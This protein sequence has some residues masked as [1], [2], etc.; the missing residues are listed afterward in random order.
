MNPSEFT[1][2]DRSTISGFSLQ[3]IVPT[4]KY[5][6]AEL[7]NLG[8]NRWTF[9]PQWGLAKNFDKWTIEGY[10]SIW[11]FTNNSNYLDGNE[12]K[13]KPLYT[14]KL[15][16]IRDLPKN[17]WVAANIGYGIGGR[18]VVNGTPKDTHISGMRFGLHYVIPFNLNHSIKFGYAS[19]VRFKKGSDFDA[20]TLTYQY[21]WNKSVKEYNKLKATK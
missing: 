19:G 15:H 1:Q 6:P 7:L 4:G 10:A 2:Y 21:R 12:L 11:L 18:A 14:A 20:V 9:K 5:N 16:L 13:Q 17:M 3:I 8:T